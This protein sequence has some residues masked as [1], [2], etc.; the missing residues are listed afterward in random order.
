M[1][2]RPASG[3]AQRRALPSF[4]QI[5]LQLGPAHTTRA[6]ARRPPA[7]LTEP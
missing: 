6:T 1:A 2:S 4:P 5:L 7:D 3:T